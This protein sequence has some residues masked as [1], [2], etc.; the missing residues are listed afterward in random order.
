MNV[1]VLSVWHVQLMAST[2]SAATTAIVSIAAAVAE[3]KACR[4]PQR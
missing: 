4:F 1:I 3:I 2:L